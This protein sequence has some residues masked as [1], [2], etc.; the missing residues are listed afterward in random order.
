MSILA[1]TVSTL[2]ARSLP[3][4]AAGAETK[5]WPPALSPLP[6]SGLGTVTTALV[7]PV[8]MPPR[9]SLRLAPA[10]LAA[11]TAE[12]P[13]GAFLTAVA[14]TITF[15]VPPALFRLLLEAG[16]PAAPNGASPC[17]GVARKP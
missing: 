11:L 8:G 13:G 3:A 12:V 10:V 7:W 1:N 2:T 15:S 17:A 9:P 5:T 14:A 16:L 6:R 4:A